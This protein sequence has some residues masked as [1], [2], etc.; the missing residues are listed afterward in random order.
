MFRALLLI[1]LIA[2]FAFYYRSVLFSGAPVLAKLRRIPAQIAIFTILVLSTVNGFRNDTEVDHLDLPRAIETATTGSIAPAEPALPESLEPERAAALCL[3]Q[4]LTEAHASEDVVAQTWM[5][6]VEGYIETA[7]DEVTLQFAVGP[8]ASS[9]K[10]PQ[11]RSEARMTC[12]ITGRKVRTSH[13]IHMTG[14]QI[15]C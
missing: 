15:A 5:S 14:G 11:C 9:Q 13:P 12:Q 10:G 6:S 1:T 2:A 8:R 3:E 7:P 4:A